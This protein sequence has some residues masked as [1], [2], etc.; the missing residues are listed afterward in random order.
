MTSILAIPKELE[1]LFDASIYDIEE[2]FH[3][4]QNSRHESVL[5][6]RHNVLNKLYTVLMRN[7]DYFRHSDFIIDSAGRLGIDLSYFRRYESSDQK[8]LLLQTDA[9]IAA[10]DYKMFVDPRIDK[11]RKEEIFAD[12]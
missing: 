11:N 6:K 4:A 10:V 8:L 9:T 3:T 1:E 7:Q 2:K 5:R 12:I